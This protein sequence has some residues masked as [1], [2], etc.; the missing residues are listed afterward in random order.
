MDRS[1]ALARARANASEHTPMALVQSVLTAYALRG[2]APDEAMR[3]AQIAPEDVRLGAG[4]VSAH[5]FEQLCAA[6]MQE[7]DDE[8]L[9]WFNRRLPWGSYG[10]LA[11]AS[12]TASTLGVA[13]ARWCR[14]HGLLTDGVR[15][16]LNRG[17]ERASVLVQER[18]V[19]PALREFALL[20]LLRNLHGLACWMLDAQIPLHAARFPFAAP[21]HAAVYERLFPGPIHFL[22]AS[23]CLEFDAAY[24]D[25]ALR[26]DGTALDHMLRRALPIVVWPYRRERATSARV[27]QLLQANPGHTGQSLADQ[28][29]LSPRSLHRQLQAEGASL[30]ALKDSV[31]QARATDLLL[32]TRQPLKRVALE[33]GFQNEKSFI[34]AF[35]Q[36]SGQ[37]PEQLRRLRSGAFASD[38]IS[39]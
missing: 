11:R 30:Q 36:W 19:N 23:A 13:L 33:A 24:L 25:L 20:A 3:R 1:T 7:L 28:L 32:R 34:R 6:A 5:Q 35:R 4:G 14:H 10:M 26:R 38:D 39:Y 21:P 16:V 17:A 2:V 37:T 8:A 22:A 12:I 9:G 27:R 18:G 31:R 29:A 15:L